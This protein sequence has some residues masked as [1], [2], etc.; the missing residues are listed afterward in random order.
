MGGKQG[1]VRVAERDRKFPFPEKTTLSGKLRNALN[2]RGPD[3][4]GPVSFD[5]EPSPE[6]ELN[7]W[8][9]CFSFTCLTRAFLSSLFFLLLTLTNLLNHPDFKIL[10]N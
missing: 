4:K 2:R 5:A 9:P 1:L 3:L 8:I 6:Q 7:H 10:S